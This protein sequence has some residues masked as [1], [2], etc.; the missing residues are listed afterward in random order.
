MAIR[1]AENWF[2]KDFGRR[3]GCV[4][5]CVCFVGMTHKSPWNVLNANLKPI[6]INNKH[7]FAGRLYKWIHRF[8]RKI[9]SYS[10]L[11]VFVHEYYKNAVNIIIWNISSHYIWHFM[12]SLLMML[13]NIFFLLS[14]CFTSIASAASAAAYTYRLH[15][16][17]EK[18]RIG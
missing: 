4:C 6:N 12:R 17:S 15:T 3:C 9:I 11:F 14:N 5:A 1:I 10:E 18:K 16:S 13:R 2:K 7:H 8:F